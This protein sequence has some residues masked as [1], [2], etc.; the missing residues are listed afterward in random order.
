MNLEMDLDTLHLEEIQ[1]HGR[2]APEEGYHNPDLALAFVHVVDGTDEVYERAFS[3][4][5]GLAAFQADIHAGG[6]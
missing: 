5:H 2:F 4:P 6:V 3:D 1:F